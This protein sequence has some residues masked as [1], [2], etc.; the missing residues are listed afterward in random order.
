VKILFLVI[1]FLISCKQQNICEQY[2]F[3]GIRGRKWWWPIF[4]WLLDISIN[5]AWLL[6]RKFSEA[7]TKLEF[8]RELAQVYLT[9]Y[10]TEVKSP[11]G[12]MSRASTSRSGSADELRYDMLRHFITEIP[13][14]KRRRCAYE[15]CSSRGRTMCEKCD[16]GLCI[17]CFKNYHLK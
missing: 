14:Q 10:K 17:K 9:R 7:K 13:G 8:R 6:K 16:V 5:N 12:Q 11:G 2:F 3:S 1:S 15:G 4:T